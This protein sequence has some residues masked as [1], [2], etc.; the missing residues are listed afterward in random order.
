MKA[1][2]LIVKILFIIML[3]LAGIRVVVS[4]SISTSGVALDRINED[5]ASV[6]TDNLLIEEKLLSLT[7]LNNVASEAAKLGFA[8]NNDILIIAN[9]LPIA[10]KQ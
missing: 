6:K 5:V 1:Y 2:S 10:A 7:S 9:P 4:N 3:L 8:S